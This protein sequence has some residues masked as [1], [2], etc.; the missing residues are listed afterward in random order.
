ML[1][2]AFV[3]LRMNLK[4]ECK[5]IWHILHTTKVIK[6]SCT[7]FSVNHESILIFHYGNALFLSSVY[8]GI[9]LTAFSQG[10]KKFTHAFSKIL[11]RC[12]QAKN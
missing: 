1:R 5:P 4:F 10:R 2:T 6:G 11:L 12:D 9:L 3:F 7:W 8:A